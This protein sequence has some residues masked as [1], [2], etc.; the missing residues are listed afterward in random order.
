MSFVA[1]TIQAFEGAPLPDLMRRA[2]I[3]LLVANA[4]RQLAGAPDD[5]EARFAQQMA[6]HP[7][8]EHADAANA[9]HYELPSD[10]FL[11]CLARS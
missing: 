6:D 2:A 3:E 9:Q 1:S 10:F 8:A 7:I 11:A 4:R 5:A